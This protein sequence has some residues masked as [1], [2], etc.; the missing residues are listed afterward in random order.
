M[1]APGD[2]LEWYTGR[3]P[4]DVLGVPPDADARQVRDAFNALQRDLQEKGLSPAELAKQT[5]ALQVAYDQLRDPAERV[6]VDF[7][8]LDRNLG[9]KQCEAIAAGVKKPNTEVEGVVK[10]RNIRVTHEVL[11]DQ[12]A[13]YF[14]DPP[15][16]GGLF[17]A[18]MELGNPEIPAAL[19]VR[20][21]C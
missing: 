11:Y 7:R 21:D 15:K 12:L 1:S 8:L 20:F 4:Y 6:R 17:P 18:P 14:T 3:T 9:K 5:Q 19:D 16:V 10:P 2:V 13:E